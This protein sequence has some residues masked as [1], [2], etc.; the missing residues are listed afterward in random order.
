[1]SIYIKD[2]EKRVLAPYSYKKTLLEAG[3]CF[4]DS[5][6]AWL[7]GVD[8]QMKSPITGF[9]SCGGAI[10]T[11]TGIIFTREN[12]Q[13]ILDN[14][15]EGGVLKVAGCNK[16]VLSEKDKYSKSDKTVKESFDQDNIMVQCNETTF[17]PGEE[18]R[19]MW[20][21]QER[22]RQKIEERTPKVM[23]LSQFFDLPDDSEVYVMNVGVKNYER[24][25]V[26]VNRSRGKERVT[27]ISLSSTTTNIK[28][29]VE[30][31]RRTIP[32]DTYY[33]IHIAGGGVIST[34]FYTAPENAIE[35]FR[36]Y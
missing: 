12:L 34:Y 6:I 11:N 36:P 31:R 27:S 4:A 17:A 23:T 5:T 18:A 28:I 24:F 35:E 3:T 16:L 33:Y 1:M 2:G 29:L 8:M 15:P 14:L 20:I 13:E 10:N 9:S 19:Q 22:E 7:E 26:K 30:N 21:L 32:N 25:K